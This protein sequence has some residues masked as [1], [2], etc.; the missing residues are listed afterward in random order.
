MNTVSKAWSIEL[1]SALI[2]KQNGKIY[3]VEPAPR[4]LFALDLTIDSTN[5]Y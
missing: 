5:E 1:I 3:Q 2:Y 4:T